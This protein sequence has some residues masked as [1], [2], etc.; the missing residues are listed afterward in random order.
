MP[1]FCCPLSLAMWRDVDTYPTF[2]ISGAPDA[3]IPGDTHPA[4]PIAR[5]LPQLEVCCLGGVTE[6]DAHH[7]AGCVPRRQAF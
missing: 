1:W 7:H 3:L 5:C 4:L 2:P 6:V